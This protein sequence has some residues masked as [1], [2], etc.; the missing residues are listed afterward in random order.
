M[1]TALKVIFH[2]PHRGNFTNP[3]NHYKHTKK[4]KQNKLND[5]EFITISI[6][7]ITLR[8]IGSVLQYR[9]LF[10]I[11]FQFGINEHSISQF[12]GG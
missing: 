9:C 10:G 11:Q 8:L 12:H 4:V 2:H 5:I 6:T 1:K 3:L 7:W